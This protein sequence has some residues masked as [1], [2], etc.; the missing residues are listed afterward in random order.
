LKETATTRERRLFRIHRLKEVRTV[1]YLRHQIAEADGTFPT[2]REVEF[3]AERDA[4]IPFD[5]WAV[6]LS[7]TG[8]DKLPV[9][10][11][12]F[13]GLARQCK[14]WKHLLGQEVW[15]GEFD[16]EFVSAEPRPVC[17][18]LS[19]NFIDWCQQKRENWRG[20]QGVLAKRNLPMWAACGGAQ[21]LAILA[22]TGADQP[23]DC[24][25]CRESAA[26][27]LPIYTHI[28]HTAKRPCG[29]YS[30][31]LFERGPTNVLQVT[32]DP[33]FEGLP[34]EFRT[35]ESH[36]GQIQWAPKGW[37]LIATRGEGG[38][39]K[40]QCLRVNDRFIYAAQFHM[41]ME[42]TP[43]SYR[44]LMGNFLK[45]AQNWGGYNP[46][47]KAVPE[48]KPHTSDLGPKPRERN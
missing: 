12:A 5:D 2:L 8:D 4:R 44:V 29:D 16:E 11:P 42:G 40:T 6:V 21:G 37:T 9:S 39:T 25:H 23:W 13:L 20:L 14:G 19:G 26:P 32:D 47:G 36:C 17:A 34:R 18:F 15:L 7:T 46:D 45:L 24:P 33:V 22:E 1:K 41:E 43:D 35:M 31:C 38:K 3:Y 27:K 48:P 10:G 30:A 28:G